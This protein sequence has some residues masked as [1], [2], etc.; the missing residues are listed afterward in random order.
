MVATKLQEGLTECLKSLGGKRHIKSRW[1]VGGCQ[2]LAKSL[3]LSRLEIEVG[4]ASN[5]IG[6]LGEVIFEFTILR[7]L[8]FVPAF[9]GDKWESVD[10]LV[11]LADREQ[12]GFFFVQVKSTAQALSNERFP[13]MP[14]LSEKLESLFSYPAPTYIAFVD[15]NSRKVYLKAAMGRDRFTSNPP[16]ELTPETSRTLEEEV[17][18]Y[19]SLVETS[20]LKS[21]FESKFG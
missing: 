5:S 3:T 8:R 20:H 11:E 12:H 13:S 10:Y 16:V 21:T 17:S 15:T 18:G 14:I 19:W 4:R 9:L 6:R 2:C 7:E 1:L